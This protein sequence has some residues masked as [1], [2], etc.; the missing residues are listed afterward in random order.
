MLNIN[1]STMLI[2]MT[3]GDTVSI[4]FSAVDSNGDTYYPQVGD[5]LKFAV[6]KKV[7]ADPLFEIQ[8]EQEDIK[9]SV[10]VTEDEF[11]ADKTRFY[12]LSGDVYT[13]CTDASVYDENE[14]YYTL[15][16]TDFWTITIPSASTNELKFGDYV[17]DVQLTNSSGVDT[18]IGKTD[19]ISPTLRIW[20][21]VATE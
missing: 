17:Y 21:E 9:T 6:A 15:D 18:I 1:T 20:G 13:Q 11:N 12:T 14:T 4:V 19:T 2:E 10:E 5:T 3:R 8:T 16:S 7:G